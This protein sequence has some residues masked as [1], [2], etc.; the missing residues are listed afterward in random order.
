VNVREAKELVGSWIE[1]EVDYLPGLR[2]A[3]LSGSITAM[4]NATPF[5]AH[6]DVDL[7]LVFDERSPLLAHDGPEPN[8][9]QVSRGGLAI[10]IGLKPTA[11]YASPAAVLANPEIAFHL[12][13]D[14]VLYDPHGLLRGLQNEVRRDYPR[15]RWVEARLAH[16]RA[17]LAN[18][19]ELRSLMRDHWDA[20]IQTS[21]LGYTTTF[22]VAAL[23]VASLQPPKMGGRMFSRVRRLLAA[24]GRLDLHEE[25][26]ALLGLDRVERAEV[27]RYLAEATAAFELALRVRRSP[28]PFAFK[29]YPHILPVWAA[30]CQAMLDEGQHREALGWVLPFYLAASDIVVADGSPAERELWADRR[31]RFL[32]VLGLLS[33]QA[34]EARFAEAAALHGRLFD[35]A[36]EIAE[37]NPVIVD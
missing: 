31:T 36:A 26:L 4:A 29:A 6:K 22:P 30:S 1:E 5:P 9:R 28:H 37:Q 11:H 20:S 33:D 24:H 16:E 12:T 23:W 14:S 27:E 8:I 19:L 35:L 13:V 10:E 25:L 15:R 2:A 21:M 3:H 34:R 32:D 7:L 17:A 18:V